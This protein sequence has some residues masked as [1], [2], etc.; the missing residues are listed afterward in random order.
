MKLKFSLLRIVKINIKFILDPPIDRPIT[1]F[2]HFTAL[3]LKVIGGLWG[4][5]RSDGLSGSAPH[6]IPPTVNALKVT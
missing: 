5:Y 4:T 3:S 1:L 6:A 2:L